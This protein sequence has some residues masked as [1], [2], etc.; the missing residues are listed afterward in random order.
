[1]TGAQI[2][3]A[4][5]GSTQTVA[6]IDYPGGLKSLICSTN[7]GLVEQIKLSIERLIIIEVTGDGKLLLLDRWNVIYE[8]IKKYYGII[9]DIIKY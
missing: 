1:M 5:A 9:T 8:K 2:P 7:D 4:A 6:G 3:A